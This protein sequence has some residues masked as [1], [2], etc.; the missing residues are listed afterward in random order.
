VKCDTTNNVCYGC[1]QDSDCEVPTTPFCNT[2]TNECVACHA[3]HSDSPV[4]TID[5]QEHEAC[6]ALSP[7]TYCHTDGSCRDLECS[8]PSDCE[9]P[10]I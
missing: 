1:L 3:F 4:D 5:P 2:S 6:F 7:N 8:A 9:V 10:G